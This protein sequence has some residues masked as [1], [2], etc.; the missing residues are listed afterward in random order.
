MITGPVHSKTQK[1]LTAGFLPRSCEQR[2]L[3]DL[4]IAAFG[5]RLTL[6]SKK[7]KEKKISMWYKV[8]ANDYA[9]LV[10]EC[11]TVK[12]LPTALGVRSGNSD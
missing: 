7:E 2:V 11:D 6:V 10:G 1:A 8:M 5:G 12:W 9:C 4:Q 3:E